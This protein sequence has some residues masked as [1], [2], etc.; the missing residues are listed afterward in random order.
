MAHESRS[1]PAWG[2]HLP[3]E[4]RITEI[5]IVS[6]VTDECCFPRWPF[7]DRL[8]AGVVGARLVTYR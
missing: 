6:S 2:S 7:M 8:L 4:G 1:E 3:A 5:P